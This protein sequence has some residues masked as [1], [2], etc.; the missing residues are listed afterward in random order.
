MELDVDAL[1]AAAVP[2]GPSISAFPPVFLDLAFV[3]AESVTAAELESA[4]RESAG[5]LLEGVRLFDVYTGPQLGAGRKSLAYSLTL[6]APDRT[7]S[8]E[9]AGAVRDRVIAFAERA[10]RAELRG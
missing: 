8:G 10:H 4:I 3:V 7:L 6:R 2:V 9:E 5:E 1:R